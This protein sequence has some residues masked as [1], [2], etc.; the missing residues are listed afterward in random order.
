MDGYLT[1][2]DFTVEVRDGGLNRLGQILPED[3][4]L[5][6]TERFNNVGEW[7]LTLP[8]EHPL[9][10]ALRT[11]GAGII[12]TIASGPLTGTT[13]V[14]GP[15]VSPEVTTSASDPGTVTIAGA[16]DNVLL[17]DRLVHPA[18]V[19]LDPA[20]ASH[21]VR[22]GP[23]ETLM[24]QYVNV[25]LAAG[26]HASRV[27]SRVVVPASLGRGDTSTQRPRFAVLGSLLA[28]IAAG[29]NYP[30]VR[31]SYHPG[32]LGF[33]IVQVDSTLEFQVYEVTD[34]AL[35]VRLDVHNGTLASHKVTTAAPTVT[36]VIV[37]GDG[38]GTDRTIVDRTTA[39]ATAAAA[40]WHRRIELLKDQR[41]TSDE[42]ELEQAGDAE[43]AEGGLSQYAMEVVPGDDSGWEFGVDWNLGDIV[44]VVVRDGGDASEYAAS[45]YATIV[46]GYVLKSD[47]SG[48][49]MG[50]VLGTPQEDDLTKIERRLS[51]L[52]ANAEGG[53]FALGPDLLADNGTRAIRLYTTGTDLAI[54]AGAAPLTISTWS[55]ADFTGTQYP[56]LIL[57]NDAGVLQL[58]AGASSSVAATADDHLIRRDYL[59]SRLTPLSSTSGGASTYAANTWYRVASFGSGATST[60][61]ARAAARV[62]ISSTAPAHHDEIII[63]VAVLHNSATG[64]T[65][66]L[67][68]YSGYSSVKSFVQARL[69]FQNTGAY[70]GAHLEILTAVAATSV[71]MEIRVQHR[72]VPDPITPP[73]RWAPE[74]TAVATTPPSPTYVALS[75]GLGYTGEF[76]P[77][78]FQNGWT[79]Y[80]STFEQAGYRM[81]AGSMVH[82]R[83][84]IKS[85]TLS[86]TLPAFTLP[87]GYRPDLQQLRIV[88][89]NN[90]YGR[91]DIKAN[92]DVVIANGSNAYTSLDGISFL[93]EQ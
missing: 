33:R 10:P 41:S 21:D 77:P 42:T 65:M 34:R 25:N 45:E 62:I 7:K 18:P 36:N 81:A 27:D 16:T 74:W 56:K 92:G 22:T 9:A 23:A 37:A 14:S 66:N 43:L 3:L 48:T 54:D 13:L 49:R 11:P 29:A 2:F 90:A 75:R 68:N 38:E 39:E 1:M 73:F 88:N 82:L 30:A 19:T 50:A 91:V 24:T 63:D 86:T 87:A 60:D 80:S 53:N 78:T 64:S 40:A 83:G 46:T 8:I 72:D 70:A 58:P 5:T 76:I 6:I 59:E 12:V 79:N 93:A 51:N 61:H 47:A 32:H 89:A 67:V 71:D 17:A 57:P 85:G 26:A 44:S 69:V 35:D 28:T 84:L 20:D 52:E 31:A 55:A 4:N 15:M